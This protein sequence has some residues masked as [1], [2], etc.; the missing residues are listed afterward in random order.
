MERCVFHIHLITASSRIS[1]MSEYNLHYAKHLSV[2]LVVT[3]SSG[4][5]LSQIMFECLFFDQFLVATF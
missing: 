2:H 3:T 1:V 5:V 4:F